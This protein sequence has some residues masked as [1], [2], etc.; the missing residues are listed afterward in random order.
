MYFAQ[1]VK[2]AGGTGKFDHRRDVMSVDDQVVIRGNRDTLYS[3]AVFDLDAGPVTIALPNV[4]NRY[5]SMIVIDEDHYA[6]G[7]YYGTQPVVLTKEKIGTRYVLVG[8]R[9]FIDPSDPGD[10]DKTHALQDAIKVNQKNSG[11]WEA[12][13]WDPE[14]QKKVR[15]ALVVLAN[16]IP[17][18]KRMYGPKNE[19]DPIR[20]LI[21][22]AT[23]WGANSEKDAT[24]IPVVPA[25]N[26]GTTIYKLTAKDVPVDGFWSITVYNAKGYLD[27]NAFN[28]YSL[29][30]VTAKKDA[31]GSITIQFGGCD[32]KIPN[33]LP[34]SAGWNY[35]VRLYRPR[36]QVVNGQWKFPEAQPVS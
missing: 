27:K 1:S 18:T 36:A 2:R 22:T 24:Y 14:S 9:T 35:W 33:C 6:H 19:V 28:A 8:I 23:G 13:K 32:G 4:A 7:T 15:E 3:A 21:G 29:N 11:S 17:D 31:D 20:H 5:M 25:R 26:D 12:P 30:N 16:T 34:I 10:L